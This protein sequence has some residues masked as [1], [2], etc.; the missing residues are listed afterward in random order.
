MDSLT[1]NN[2]Y[3]YCLHDPGSNSDPEGNFISAALITVAFIGLAVGFAS[4]AG[5]YIVNEGGRLEER[6]R[7]SFQ[8][9]ERRR[10]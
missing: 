7:V 8:A 10:Q 1:G 4:A 2:M 9:Q 6:C 3:A 5:Q